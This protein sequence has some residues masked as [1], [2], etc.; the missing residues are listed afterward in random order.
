M[1]VL[2]LIRNSRRY[3]SW[4]YNKDGSVL[5]Y[6]EMARGWNFGKIYKKQQIYL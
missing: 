2:L 6:W 5:T 1:I 3:L 4:L